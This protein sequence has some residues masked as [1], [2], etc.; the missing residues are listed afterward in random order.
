[1]SA[2]N[3]FALLAFLGEDCAGAIRFVCKE[4]LQKIHQGG[5]KRLTIAQIEARLLAL[6]HDL[7][8]SRTLEDQG[9]FSLAGAQAKTAFQKVGTEWFL[10]WGNEPTTHILK[11]PRVDLSGHVENE[12]FCLQLAAR[13][14]LETAS[15]EVIHFGKESAIVVKRYDRVEKKGKFLRFHQED[16][17]QALSIAPA[18]KY[19][20]MGGPGI[21]AIMEL[22]NQSSQPKEDRDRFMQAIIFNYLILGS[23]AHGKNYS[24][25]LG[26]KGNVRLAPL[27]DVASLLPYV[28]QPRHQRLSM[29]IDRSYRD[30]QIRPHHFEKMARCCEYP[31]AQL[32]ETMQEYLHKIPELSKKLRL[33]LSKNGLRHPILKALEDKLE[34]RCSMLSKKFC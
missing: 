24:L 14:G 18:K 27:Y 3:P 33:E 8:L 10:P 26:N 5:K 25:L 6:K 28:S 12:H 31:T 4:N 34:K 9:Q 15:S 1:M 20:N 17:C 11:P 29:G 32:H 7:S 30:D 16:L 23:D 2:S 22:L 21:P 19:E 13:L